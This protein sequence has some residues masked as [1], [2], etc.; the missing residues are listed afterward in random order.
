MDKTRWDL[1]EKNKTMK[2]LKSSILINNE[3][4]KDNVL[5]TL[6]ELSNNEFLKMFNERN[7][8]F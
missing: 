5:E 4:F 3:Q 1:I 8:E 2:R 6:N 7:N